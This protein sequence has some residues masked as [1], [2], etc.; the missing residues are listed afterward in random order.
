MRKK[1]NISQE[2]LAKRMNVS[3]QAVYKWE[4]GLNAPELEKI[5]MLAE[6]FDISYD[7]LLDEKIDL[8]VYFSQ[9]QEEQEQEL[10]EKNQEQEP[11]SKHIKNEKRRAI[12]I[13]VIV[14]VAL[15]IGVTVL[16]VV[17]V[18]N[19]I[20]DSGND[21]STN[22]GTDTSTNASTDI[23]TDSSTDTDTSISTDTNPSTPP[24]QASIKL[25]M[26]AENMSSNKTIICN[27]GE[28]IGELP[29]VELVGHIFVG[30]F[31]KNDTEYKNQITNETIVT[32][33]MTELV[34]VHIIDASNPPVIVCFDANGGIM[35]KSD[36][37]RFVVSGTR[38]GELPS[39]ER[40]GYKLVGWYLDSDEY[41]WNKYELGTIITGN[42]Y[43]TITLKAVW[44][45]KI[46]CIDGGETH[47]W[48]TWQT[49]E[50]ATCIKPR[51]D[52]HACNECGCV[53]VVYAKNSYTDHSLGAEKIAIE[54]DCVTATVYE[55]ACTVCDY[56]KKREV[57]PQGHSYQNGICE[58]CKEAEFTKGVEYTVSGS[59]AYVSGYTGSDKIVKISPTYTPQGSDT[60]Y[61]VTSIK[62]LKSEIITEL[63]IPEGAISIG[64]AFDESNWSLPNLETVHLPTTLEKISS[65]AFKSTK[66]NK[67]YI[68]SLKDF[69][70]IT[71]PSAEFS[72]EGMTLKIHSFYDLYLN[73]ELVTNLH[74]TADI[75]RILPYAF[76]YCKSIK[77]LTMD[78]CNLGADRI[79]ERGAFYSC[80]IQT[81]E[82][83]ANGIGEQAF[84]MCRDLV[85]VNIMEAYGIG[86]NAFGVCYRLFEVY[87]R[88]EMHLNPGD[89]KYGEVARLVKIVKT[90]ASEPS[91]ITTSSDGVV[92]G[93]ANNNYYLI[94]YLGNSTELKLPRAIAG[95]NY[96]IGRYFALSA[97]GEKPKIERIWVPK[98]IT[99]IE[100]MGLYTSA[101]EILCEVAQK[102]S[103]WDTIFD[104]NT[105]V[106]Y[107]Q[108]FD[109]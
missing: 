56:T 87:A 75:T 13:A 71:S 38:L 4:A 85:S 2:Q 14:A 60:S 51:K 62:T 16:V 91:S 25:I 104:A 64:D 1:R 66:I 79:I 5:Y 98:E 12:I 17:L 65:G 53:E 72:A 44:K 31:E 52:E 8:E 102:P 20:N 95:K 93:Y 45:E 58:I 76:A 88:E 36:E 24:T 7:L 18:N 73:N 19:N 92:I 50:E 32:S 55:S 10:I 34:P 26:G 46:F 57:A 97:C 37:A 9:A 103:G 82:I 68:S 15:F 63:I 23:S 27:V 40:E 59:V 105:T 81:A 21:T 54:G 41:N 47:F 39:I 49:A 80:G 29:V 74:L 83:K 101:L 35:N 77:A 6:I 78:S 90:S 42:V 108:K 22:T 61:P 84:Y 28:P 30:W 48:G 69:C 67:V 89:T 11:Q 94:M 70:E 43:E 99:T 33:E 3:R 107:S 106:L 100:A 96:I 109:Y 86:N